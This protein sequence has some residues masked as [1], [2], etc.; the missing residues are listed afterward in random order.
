VA[1]QV[2]EVISK[3]RG[4][5]ESKEDIREYL[6]NGSKHC[7]KC[8]ISDNENKTIANLFLI[9]ENVCDEFELHEDA[10]GNCDSE[11]LQKLLDEWCKEQTG[12]TT[13]KPFFEQYVVIPYEEVT[14]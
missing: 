14:T 10:L 9:A 7:Y 2:W 8:V 11:S 12:A 4:K 6:I 3:Q 5:G 1:K 13:Y